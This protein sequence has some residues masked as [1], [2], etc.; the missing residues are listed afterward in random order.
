MTRNPETKPRTKNRFLT[1]MLCA[2]MMGAGFTTVSTRSASAQQVTLEQVERGLSSLRNQVSRLDARAEQ[3]WDAYEAAQIRRTHDAISDAE[4]NAA[5]RAWREASRA[6]AE[7]MDAYEAAE[8][9]AVE[10]RMQ[11]IGEPGFASSDE[12]DAL[13]RTYTRLVSRARDTLRHAQARQ[14]AATSWHADGQLSEIELDAF[15]SDRRQASRALHAAEDELA[16][17]ERFV[18]LARQGLSEAERRAALEQAREERRLA[19]ERRRAEEAR[20]AAARA[21]AD[22]AEANRRAAE[23]RAASARAQAQARA[24]ANRR[25]AEA[26]AASARAHAQARAE[27]NRRAAEARAEAARLAAAERARRARAQRPSAQGGTVVVRPTAR[28]VDDCPTAN[29]DGKTSSVTARA[30]VRVAVR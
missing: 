9:A 30:W 7:A 3:T 29:A 15:R 6:R 25:A 24:E 1:L 11:H 10:T 28:P 21:A 20:E 16:S 13:V 18:T 26:R 12:L 5:R 19:N 2:A 23:A 8:A 14:D 22:R 17:I 27:A 4:Y